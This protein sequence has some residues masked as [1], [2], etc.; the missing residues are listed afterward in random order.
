MTL[1][2]A[3]F[4]VG[5]APGTLGKASASRD[6]VVEGPGAASEA[7]AFIVDGAGVSVVTAQ[8]GGRC[9]IEQA[10]AIAAGIDGADIT[11]VTVRQSSTTL[12]HEARSV[13]APSTV[14]TAIAGEWIV[15]AGTGDAGVFGARIPVITITI[16]RAGQI[17][18]IPLPVG[19]DAR[20]QVLG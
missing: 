20:Y 3:A 14:A 4:V 19:V 11:V 13:L 5:A 17:Q 16:D 7:V 8:S 18:G 9:V 15:D 12:R 10:L 1:S 6:R 2:G